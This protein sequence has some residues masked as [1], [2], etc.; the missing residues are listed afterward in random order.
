MTTHG[1]E[2][3]RFSGYASVFNRIDAHNDVIKP[4]AFLHS[5]KR[6][7]IALLWQHSVN[8]P[9]GKILKSEE[10]NFGLL[11]VAK[12]NLALRRAREIYSLM[13]DGSINSLSIGYRV[14][15]VEGNSTSSIR[16]ISKI[17]LWE[18]SLVT[19]PANNLAKISEVKLL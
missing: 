6:R 7:R 12:L 14:I 17:D 11:V 4:G 10:D 18:V 2:P 15:Q 9:I 13:L 16:V 19:F 8:E 5:I 1:K 3:G